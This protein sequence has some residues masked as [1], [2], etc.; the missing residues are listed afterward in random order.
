MLLYRPLIIDWLPVPLPHPPAPN[1]RCLL[2]HLHPLCLCLL[3][4]LSPPLVPSVSL[5]SLSCLLL[6]LS[7]S[8]SLSFL[9]ALS[10]SVALLVQLCKHSSLIA[11]HLCAA[12]KWRQCACKKQKVTAYYSPLQVPGIVQ[13]APALRLLIG[14]AF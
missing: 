9:S 7:L 6:F 2:R 12:F 13:Q 4:S 1:L 8:L 10:S 3:V 14:A 5:S 11:S